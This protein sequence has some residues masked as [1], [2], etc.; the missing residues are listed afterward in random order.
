MRIALLLSVTAALF[1]AQ[2]GAQE[3]KPDLR[4][5]LIAD[6]QYADADPS[7]TRYYRNSLEKLDEC[8]E[9]LNGEKVDFTVNMGDAI[10]RDPAD[11]DPVLER[12]GRLKGKV[13]NTTG[14]HDYSGIPT[15]NGNLYK[16]L[17]MPSE[18]YSFGKKDWVFIMLNTNEISEYSGVGDTEKEKKLAAM[19]DAFRSRGG[20]QPAPWNGGVSGEQL[21]WLDSELARAERSGEKVL[22]FCHHPLWPE[23]GLTALNNLEILDTIDNRSC[24][25]AVFCGHHHPGDFAYHGDIPVITVEGMVE[26]ENENAFGVVELRGDRITVKGTGRMSSREFEFDSK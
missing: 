22:I 13:F 26:T 16:K 18:Y 17:G 24:V 11:L 15:E 9:T 5:G 23:S 21:R 2:V 8:V 19:Y 1:A 4:F 10:D 6:I 7:R 25:K 3:S 20:G 14:N 12:L